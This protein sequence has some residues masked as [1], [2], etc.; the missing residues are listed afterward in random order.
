[1]VSRSTLEE[2]VFYYIKLIKLQRLLIEQKMLKNLMNYMKNG[3]R[4]RFC[5]S[6]TRDTEIEINYGW[7]EN[8]FDQHQN[9]LLKEKFEFNQ[10]QEVGYQK[11]KKEQLLNQVQGNI[12]YLYDLKG[13]LPSKAGNFAA[14]VQDQVIERL[15]IYGKK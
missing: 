14:S 9:Q 10:S 5:N 13:N 3:F 2:K 4:K 1:M 15:K 11:K 7:Q 12:S 6:L 8:L